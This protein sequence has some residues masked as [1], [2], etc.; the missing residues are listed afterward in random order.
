[1]NVCKACGQH[2][3]TTNEPHTCGGAPIYYKPIP[4]IGWECP[5]CG[6]VHAPWVAFCSCTKPKGEE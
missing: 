5:K 6:R 3:G 2:F 1:M 4:P